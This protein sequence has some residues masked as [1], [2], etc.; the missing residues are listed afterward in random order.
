MKLKL[1]SFLTIF[2]FATNAQWGTDDVVS[3]GSG[4]ANQ[5]W[6]SLENDEQ[7]TAPKNNWDL[8]FEI[9]GFTTSIRVNHPNDV[10]VWLYPDGDTADWAT[11]DTAGLAANWDN[12]YNSDTSWSY[13]AFNAGTDFN[14]QFDLGWGVYN[15]STHQV[16]GDSLFVIKLNNGDYKKLW[17]EKL[18]SGT[19]TFR[20][21]N[22]DNTGDVTVD[23]EKSNYTDRN[24]AYYSIQNQQELDREPN[25]MGWDLVFTQYGVYFPSFNY[26][27]NSTGILSNYGVETA[28]AYPVNDSS[29]YEAYNGLSFTTAIN[30]IGYEWKSLNM[31]TF[32]YEIE[33]STVYFVKSTAGEYWKIVFTGF[34][35]SANGDY[36]FTKKKL[37]GVGINELEKQTFVQVYPNPAQTN[38]NINIVL[39]GSVS[40]DVNVN[41]IDLS[42]RVVSSNTIQVVPGLKTYRIQTPAQS[43]QYIVQ[44]SSQNIQTTSKILIQ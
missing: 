13:G 38:Q 5:V 11:L 18:A 36:E 32:S 27:T 43:G 9:E 2:A 28:V 25:N 41:I 35:G 33:D 39:D 4:Y 26:F 6:Y 44:L 23:I 30:G 40:E 7:G 42:G 24:F 31:T 17:I 22:L 34:G 8:A 21:A 14:D 15:M 20:F 10:M 19:Y 3:I 29:T 16:V 12:Y 37:S 1:L